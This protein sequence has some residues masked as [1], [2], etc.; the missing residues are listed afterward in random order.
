MTSAGRELVAE[1]LHQA[2][3]RQLSWIPGSEQ[4]E[5]DGLRVFRSGSTQ[6]ALST[7]VV[8]GAPED[9]DR[10]IAMAGERLSA[11]D[12]P[13]FVDIELDRFP[14]LESA[15][16]A[17]GLVPVERRIGMTVAL[18]QLE[19]V[20]RLPVRRVVHRDELRQVRAIQSA[21]F[22]LAPSTAMDA[23]PDRVLDDPGTRIHLL[24]ED[25]RPV[26][27][28]MTF[29]GANSIGL[30]GIATVGP[31]RGQGLAAG[32]VATVL[33]EAADEG[34]DQAWLLATP[35]SVDLYR[36]LGFEPVSVWRLWGPS[37]VTPRP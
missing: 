31:A 12:L 6:P 36:R 5:V 29:P 20:T 1:G 22:G 33:A 10:A 19:P 7:A 9:P 4:I 17:H 30:F 37:P 21:A 24:V 23:L 14:D 25:A 11:R 13:L 3:A 34:L 26:T 35:P 16:E 18:D 8:A 28:A 27:V 2:W 15:A 32:V